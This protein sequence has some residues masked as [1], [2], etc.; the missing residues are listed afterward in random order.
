MDPARWATVKRLFHEALDRPAESRASFVSEACGAD[1]SLRLAVEAMLSRAREA[2]GFLESPAL[3]A[4]A[5][6]MA[7]DLASAGVG[8]APEAPVVPASPTGAAR[9]GVEIE[10]PDLPSGRYRV[11]AARPPW[12]MWIVAAVFLADVLIRTWC[13]ALGPELFGFTSRL[14]G[15]RYVVASVTAGGLAERSGLQPGDVLVTLDG[16]PFER[17][18]DERVRRPNLEIGREHRFEIERGAER[19]SLSVTIGRVP[20]FRPPVVRPASSGS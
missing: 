6:A 10:S 15:R 18:A 9:S 14:E 7:R 13:Y 20:I 16:R 1:E 5:L 12:W 4:E 3:E 17:V 2:D 8:S 19:Q 11:P